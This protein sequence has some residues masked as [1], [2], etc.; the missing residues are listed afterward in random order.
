M[1]VTQTSTHLLWSG[2]KL[3]PL[4]CSRSVEGDVRPSAGA[5]CF[6]LSLQT[7]GSAV[8]CAARPRTGTR[9]CCPWHS[10]GTALLGT[11]GMWVMLGIHSSWH[12]G[13]STAG[14]QE[15]TVSCRRAQLAELCRT[16]HLV[17]ARCCLRKKKELCQKCPFSPVLQT[18][19]FGADFASWGGPVLSGTQIRAAAVFACVSPT[20]PELTEPMWD[21]LQPHPLL[22]PGAAP[23]GSHLP[24]RGSPDVHPAAPALCGRGSPATV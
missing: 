16:E 14:L 9:G 5:Q 23:A 8:S 1:L 22:P 2:R 17:R 21:P 7:L 19:G 13:N 6:S 4:W 11:E 18:Q 15:S 12:G 3:Q 24:Q 20:D 10:T